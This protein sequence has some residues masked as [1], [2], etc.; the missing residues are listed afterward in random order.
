MDEYKQLAIDNIA[1]RIDDYIDEHSTT[2]EAVAKAIGCSRTALYQ[3][4]RGEST[5]TLYEGYQLAKLFGC[6]MTDFFVP[7]STTA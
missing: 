6:Q 3:K 5:F 2:K 7:V 4:L 1:Q